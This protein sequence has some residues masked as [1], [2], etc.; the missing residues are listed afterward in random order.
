MSKPPLKK[1]KQNPECFGTHLSSLT[2]IENVYGC[3]VGDHMSELQPIHLEF[4]TT[5]G[6]Y[7]ERILMAYVVDGVVDDESLSLGKP[8]A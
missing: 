1:H 4:E 3:P 7:N 5:C 2:R 8:L 6:I